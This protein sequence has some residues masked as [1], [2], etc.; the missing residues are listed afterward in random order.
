MTRNRLLLERWEDYWRETGREQLYQTLLDSVNQA[1]IVTD[2]EGLIRF[3]NQAAESLYGWSQAEVLGHSVLKV[4]PAV[5]IG[6]QTA[7]IMAELQQGN[8]WS[9][10]FRTC[11]RQGRKF[12]V[13]VINSPLYDENGNLVGV[14]G[15]LANVDAFRA[16]E[17]R[18]DHRAQQSQAL[19]RVIDAIHQSFDLDTIFS[20]SAAH[21]ANLLQM[22]VSIVQ[23]LPERQCWVHRVVYNPHSASAMKTYDVIPDADNPFAEKLKRLGVVQVGDTHQISDPVNEKLIGNDPGG[24]LLTPIS[25]DDQIW[26]SLTLVRLHQYT[27]W[28]PEE[29]ELAKHI[30][31]QLAIAI[32]QAQTYRQLQQELVQRRANEDHL[33]QYER[34]VSATFDGVALLD[35]HYTYRMVNQVYLD[36]NQKTREEI[37]GQS[38]ANLL[39]TDVFEST[40]RHRLDRCLQGETVRLNDWFTHNDGHQRYV[41]VTY[42]PYYELDGN[43]S[44]V[45]VTSRDITD[46]RLAQDALQR[47]ADQERAINDMTRLMHQSLE[48]ETMVPLAIEAVSTLLKADHGAVLEFIVDSQSWHYVAEYRKNLDSSSEPEPRSLY[49]RHHSENLAANDLLKGKVICVDDCAMSVNQAHQQLAKISSGAWLIVPFKV[50]QRAWGLVLSKQQPQWMDGAV[51]LAVRIADQLAI[52]ISQ[53]ELYQTARAELKKRQETERALKDRESFFQSLYEQATLGIAFCRCDGQIVQVNAK[54]CAITGYSERE[55]K[56]M[57]LGQ[58]TH[59]DD[60]ELNQEIFRQATQA[61]GSDLSVDKRYIK[62]DRTVVWVHLTTSVIRDDQGAFEVLAVI[63]QDISDRKRLE[64]ERQ[65]AGAQLRHNAMHD[66]LTQLP[67]RNLLMA[68]L[69]RSLKRMQRPPHRQFAVMF[70]DLDRFKLVND[71]LGHIAGDQLLIIIA[72][73]L[74]RLVR[75]GDLVARLGG[76]EFVVLLDNIDNISEVLT[77]ANRIL[78]TL[79]QPVQLQ[80]REVFATTSI[81]IVIGS[82]TY[83]DATELLRNADIAMYR[84]KANGKNSYALFDP[85]LHDQVMYQLQLE[86][87]LRRSLDK[88]QLKL[89][90]QPIVNLKD[91]SIFCLEALM[92]WQ[93]PERGLISPSDF[94]SIAEE[95]GVV[96]ALDH[97][98]VQTAC[99]Q[100]KQWQSQFLE[101]RQLKVSVNLSAQ[102]LHASGLVENISDALS[103]S[104]LE[105][106]HLVL[107]MTESLLIDDIPQ[108]VQLIAQ[109][110]DLS[111]SLAVDDFGTGYSSL[112]YLHRFPLSALKI[113]RSFTSNMREGMVNQDIIE[114]IVALSDRLGMVAIAEGSENMEQVQHLIHIGCEYSQGHYFCEPLPAEKIIDLFQMAYPFA[115]KLPTAQ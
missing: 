56:S 110:Q 93:H 10:E 19:A 52:G 74:R 7:E 22:Q 59:P 85:T 53:A 90:Y 89:Y 84:A 109:L 75:P 26:G 61:R 95:T 45:V 50:N 83:Q 30:A 37:I 92:R 44:G 36:W 82:S 57:T 9:G 62:K 14:I 105:G 88:Q 18:L 49:S 91:G 46:L 80:K 29:I 41:I 114:T 70:L 5:G 20:V 27:D 2:L 106:R 115:N 113:D 101:A 98:A 66:A 73:L 104:R 25:I 33:R 21:I 17:A 13:L 58:L 63:I 11:D 65:Q 79:R 43:I 99:Q 69:Q 68:Q 6:E 112:S 108:V 102:D 28:E 55:L 40:V 8:A 38:V 100:L 24:W 111:V 77:V 1:I 54:Y 94:I 96:V 87:D 97:W 72:N 64:T 31:T 35:R 47:Q 15:V 71:S 16:A 32:D 86:H 3:W 78:D 42:S 67:N 103:K 34:I 12:T 51:N 23:Y 60:R 48:V 107:E 4:V 81:G 76:D 39:G